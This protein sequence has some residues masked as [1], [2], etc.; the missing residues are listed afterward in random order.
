MLFRSVPIHPHNMPIQIWAETGMVGAVLAAM[1]LFF[2]GW[3]LKPP[4]DWPP[5]SKYAAAGLVGACV[6]ICS[7]AYSMWNEAFWASIVIAAAIIFLRARQ[8]AEPA[9]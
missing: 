8:D 9:S 6:A 4:A 2:L 5:V 1:F 7:F 3:R